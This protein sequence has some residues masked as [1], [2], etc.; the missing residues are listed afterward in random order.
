MRIL[1]ALLFLP[2][3]SYS[4]PIQYFI[5]S[6]NLIIEGRVISRHEIEYENGWNRYATVEILKEFKGKYSKN[7]IKLFYHEQQFHTRIHF[8]EE[9]HFIAFLS[10]TD[11]IVEV[12]HNHNG[13]F[14]FGSEI[15]GEFSMFLSSYIEQKEN[16]LDLLLKYLN[17]GTEFSVLSM[18][19]LTYKDDLE[20]GE[21]QI[22]YEIAKKQTIDIIHNIPLERTDYY[23][24]Q[25]FK[26]DDYD[27][28]FWCI[29]NKRIQN[30][31]VSF[32]KERLSTT[33]SRLIAINTLNYICEISK[34]H[35]KKKKRLLKEYDDNN[36]FLITKD[37]SIDTELNELIKYYINN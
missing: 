32:L 3:L 2:F 7:T 31:V 15:T 6:S 11:T 18:D 21:Q 16:K 12:I 33:T 8:S 35:S 26:V 5:D 20:I 25:C 9:E 1:I 13:K 27:L 28:L 36:Q 4:Q 19:I 34:R 37:D 24:S 17:K 23:Y 10:L 14:D 30:K 22:L 29:T